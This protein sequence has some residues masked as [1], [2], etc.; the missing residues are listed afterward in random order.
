MKIYSPAIISAKG[1]IVVGHGSNLVWCDILG[2]RYRQKGQGVD[3]L[4]PSLNHHGKRFDSIDGRHI[5]YDLKEMKK[6]LE[7]KLGFFG[8]DNYQPY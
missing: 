4:F 6:T 7:R 1:R 2:R 3:Y 8:I 5:E